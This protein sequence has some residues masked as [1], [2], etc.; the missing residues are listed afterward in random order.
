MTNLVE[1]EAMPENIRCG[2]AVEV[3][4]EDVNDEITLPLFKPAS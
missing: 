1:V 4:W 2:T 3:V